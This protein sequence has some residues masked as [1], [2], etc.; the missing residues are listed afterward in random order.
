VSVN[1][2]LGDGRVAPGGTIFGVKTGIT[3]GAGACLALALA[4]DAAL[5][6][7]SPR[8]AAPAGGLFFSVVLG[9]ES[10]VRRFID[11]Q[12]LLAWAAAAA[13]GPLE[14]GAL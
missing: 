12:A 4:G 3:P 5:A 10:R 7:L 9:S 1:A 8:D 2:L 13:A 14:Q 6:A 11:S